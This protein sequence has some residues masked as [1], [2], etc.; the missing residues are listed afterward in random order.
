MFGK[1]A[2]EYA[3]NM[4]PDTPSEGKQNQTSQTTSWF[5][6]HMEKHEKLRSNIFSANLF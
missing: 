1:C 2:V 3:V 6:M 4:Y 5:N